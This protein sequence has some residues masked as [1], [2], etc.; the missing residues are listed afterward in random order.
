MLDTLCA[1]ALETGFDEA[2]PLDIQT[3]KPNEMVRDMCAENKCRAYGKNW[4]CPP[5]CGT[6]VQCQARMQSYRRGILLQT[7]GYLQKA[8]DSRTMA[9]TEQ[10]H[11]EQFHRFAQLLR[12]KYPDALCLGTGGCRICKTCA[13]PEPCR[14]PEQACSS[15]EGYGLFV[16]Q[17]CRDNGLPYHHGE[18]T[19][20]YTACILFERKNYEESENHRHPKNLLPG[21]DGKI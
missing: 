3:L 13:W 4:T 17:V 20:T 1:L 6:L 14:F 11:L 21:S 12:Q 18:K 15:M 2:R 19:I 5:H 9:T 10:R 7:V 8:I 16:T